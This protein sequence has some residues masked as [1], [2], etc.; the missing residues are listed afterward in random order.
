MRVGEALTAVVG[1]W[2]GVNRLRMMPTDDYRESASRAT[3]SLVARGNGVTVAYT[4][5]EDGTP[6]EGLLVLGDGEEPGAVDA[7]W[8]DSWHQQPRWMAFQGRIDES[9][10][11]SVEGSYAPEAGWRIHVDPSGGT[12]AISMDNVMPGIDYRVVEGE[13]RRADAVG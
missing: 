3:I 1:E 2:V 12:P 4:W 13:Y 9:G 8:I 10:V 6:Q 11:V 7:I 5:V